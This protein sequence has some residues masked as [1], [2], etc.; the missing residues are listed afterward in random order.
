[1][2]KIAP[3]VTF[4]ELSPKVTWFVLGPRQ[5]DK[6]VEL[7][8]NGKDIDFA[9]CSLGIDIEKIKKEIELNSIFVRRLSLGI[10]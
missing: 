6:I 2:N 4:R 10:S 7:V 5:Q 1:M 3:K 8:K 9:A